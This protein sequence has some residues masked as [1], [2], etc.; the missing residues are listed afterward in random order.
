MDPL[1]L[2]LSSSGRLAPR[3]FALAVLSVYVAGVCSQALLAPEVLARTGLWSFAIVEAAIMW[4]WFALHAKRLHDADHGVGA[5]VGIMIVCS[6]AVLLFILML[7]VFHE[8]A[9]PEMNDT[10]R[11]VG[12]VA[13]WYLFAVVSGNGD[14][15]VLGAVLSVL[16]L[17]AF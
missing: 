3:P 14:F 8:V 7:A 13:I 12:L 5:A 15:G 11:F 1:A 4:M 9:S 16:M 2:F 17:V 10:S 6:L